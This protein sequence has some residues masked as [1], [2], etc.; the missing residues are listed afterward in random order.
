MADQNEMDSFIRNYL[1]GITRIREAPSM[2]SDA[3]VRQTS[4]LISDIPN[5][6][7]AEPA[8]SGASFI[9]GGGEDQPFGVS[10]NSETGVLTVNGGC[11]QIANTTTDVA[12]KTVSG[13]YVYAQIKNTGGTLD[14]FT[15]IGSAS[16]LP[17]AEGGTTEV[18]QVT[19][20]VLLAEV[21]TTGSGSNQTITVNQR[22]QG[23]FT[24]VYGVVNGRLT[25]IPLSTGGTI[26]PNV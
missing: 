19:H 1:S 20:N 15:I 3:I 8:T 12:A 23:N 24:L 22:R 9:G 7:S 13:N 14:S 6:I 2:A 25:L 10:R 18:A 4:T 17:V 26:N 11:Y 21:I 16:T 5:P